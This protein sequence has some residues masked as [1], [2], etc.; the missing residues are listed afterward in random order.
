MTYIY[1][2]TGQREQ[3]E[4]SARNLDKAFRSLFNVYGTCRMASWMDWTT[5]QY[6]LQLGLT[7]GGLGYWGCF[8]DLQDVLH[9]WH[10]RDSRQGLEEVEYE[11]VD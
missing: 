8:Y 7:A 6:N 3:V 5:G 4:K 10:L 9:I 2:L 11:R 1:K